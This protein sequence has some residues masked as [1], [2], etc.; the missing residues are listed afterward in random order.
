MLIHNAYDVLVRAWSVRWMIGAGVF[1]AA[2]AAL[3]L[4]PD[5]GFD[6]PPM[7][8]AGMTALCTGMALVTRF[9][10]QQGL[11]VP[12]RDANAPWRP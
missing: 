10:A 12:K 4:L 5:V 9:V 1:A 6:I 7:L 8:M 11:S 2:E 3:P